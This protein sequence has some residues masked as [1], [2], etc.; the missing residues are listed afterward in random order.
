MNILLNLLEPHKV[1]A[2][3]LKM[4]EK[5]RQDDKLASTRTIRAMIQFL[6]MSRRV[7]MLIQTLKGGIYSVA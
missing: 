4:V 7:Q 5:R 1:T 3:T 2:L 6:A